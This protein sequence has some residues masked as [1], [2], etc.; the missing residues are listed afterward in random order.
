MPL[1]LEECLKHYRQL[2]VSEDTLAS[3]FSLVEDLSAED[4]TTWERTSRMGEPTN[5]MT[6]LFVVS[7]GE[8]D[9]GF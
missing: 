6:I 1:K 5:R 7:P 4:V 8:V 2:I 3:K 9:G